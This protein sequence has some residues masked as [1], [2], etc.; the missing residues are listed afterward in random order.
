MKKDNDRTASVDLEAVFE[1]VRAEIEATDVGVVSELNF[2]VDVGADAI[3]ARFSQLKSFRKDIVDELRRFDV[4]NLDALEDYALAAK[5]LYNLES[6]QAPKEPSGESPE[7]AKGRAIRAKL[8]SAVRMLVE[9]GSLD[10]T[11]LRAIEQLPHGYRGTSNALQRLLG[12]ISKNEA[13][14]EKEAPS[15][16]SLVAEAMPLSVSLGAAAGDAGAVGNEVTDLRQKA[17]RLMLDA[18]NEVRAALGWVRRKQRDVDQIAPSMA[19]VRVNSAKRNGNDNDNDNP[20]VKPIEPAVPVTPRALM[21]VDAE[22]EP[23]PD[24]PFERR[25]AADKR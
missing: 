15:A 7:L 13:L 14:F 21:S 20:P 17:T 23:L 2:S 6:V 11:Q 24:S 10:I 9:W 5:Y 22:V 25:S 18:Y 12:L 4:R 8:T 1:R 19:H 16:L 3:L